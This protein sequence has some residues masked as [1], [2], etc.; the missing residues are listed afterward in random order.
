MNYKNNYDKNDSWD[1]KK[2]E[3]FDKEISK[4]EES[5]KFKKIIA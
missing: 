3:E 1:E 4:L 5:R 2:N